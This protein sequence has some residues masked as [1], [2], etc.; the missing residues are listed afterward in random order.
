MH[1]HQRRPSRLERVRP[2]V[3]AV[4]VLEVFVHVVTRSD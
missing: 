3:D 2:V 1:E 4:A